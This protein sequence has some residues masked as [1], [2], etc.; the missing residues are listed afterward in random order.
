MLEKNVVGLH[1]LRPLLLNSLE[2]IRLLRR[3]CLLSQY[4]LV[5]RT[6]LRKVVTV[7]LLQQEVV[8]KRL[9]DSEGGCLLFVDFVEHSSLT[10]LEQ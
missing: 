5:A 1:V 9:L 6:R 3:R 8:L 4:F 7:S 10:W 2:L